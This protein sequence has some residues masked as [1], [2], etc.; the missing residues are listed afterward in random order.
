[1]IPAELRQFA[2]GGI[3]ILGTKEVGL[4]GSELDQKTSLP[5]SEIVEVKAP[6]QRRPSA[7]VG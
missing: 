5:H 2:G 1:M 3:R 7:D 6:H 4:A